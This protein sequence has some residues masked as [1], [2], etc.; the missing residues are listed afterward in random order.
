MLK[1]AEY[2][3]PG[4]GAPWKAHLLKLPAPISSKQQLSPR[5]KVPHCWRVIYFMATFSPSFLLSVVEKIPLL[6]S[7]TLSLSFLQKAKEI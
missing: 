3:T 4:S 2:E 5:L 7:S 1:K 6:P